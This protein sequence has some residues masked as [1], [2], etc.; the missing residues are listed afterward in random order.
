MK[1]T[2]FINT[3]V[4]GILCLI[5]KAD[6]GL[7]FFLKFVLLGLAIANLVYFLEK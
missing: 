2:L 5:W 3:C 4:F 6:D 1:E 7:N